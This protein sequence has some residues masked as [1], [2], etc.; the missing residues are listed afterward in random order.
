MYSV[1]LWRRTICRSVYAPL[2]TQLTTE[3]IILNEVI[4]FVCPQIN[5]WH[6]SLALFLSL[7]LLLLFS[8]VYLSAFSHFISL[9]HFYN[10]LPPL[11][12]SP[13]NKTWP[14]RLERHLVLLKVNK[15]CISVHMSLKYES[16]ADE[17]AAICGQAPS[18][19][20]TSPSNFI[21]MLLLCT[22]FIC[23]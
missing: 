20:K 4:Y 6:Q 12:F 17:M 22:Y 19:K 18:G 8:N 2:A 1:Q 23:Q 16:A 9:S 10:F 21:S 15:V 13:W 14:Q 5:V 3:H 11:H 7:C